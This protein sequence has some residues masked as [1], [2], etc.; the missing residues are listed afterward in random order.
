MQKEDRGV[1]IS[2]GGDFADLN[3][4]TK[5]KRKKN[6]RHAST[7]TGDGSLGSSK[8][9]KSVNDENSQT[10]SQQQ[11]ALTPVTKRIL[12]NNRDKNDENIVK[13]SI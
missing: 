12:N 11:Q 5:E 4:K 1:R 6:R 10:I 7:S 13:I 9:P 8:V 2:F 3:Q